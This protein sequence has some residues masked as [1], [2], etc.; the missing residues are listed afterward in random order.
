MQLLSDTIYGSF[1]DVAKRNPHKSALIHLGERFPYSQLKEMVL[2]FA[3]SLHGLGI[4]E[5]DRVILN[6]YNL[7]QAVIA[8]LALQRLKA[9]PILVA[10][11]YTSYDLKYMANDSG[12]ETIVCMDTNLR[13]VLEILPE[14][15]LKR[16]VVTNMI[17]LVPRWKRFIC[18]GF[19]R[20][21]K[22]KIPSGKDFFS[23]SKLLSGGH[24][25]VLPA[26]ESTGRDR[27]AI[28]LYTGG[29]T[30]FPKGVPLSEKLVLKRTLE[31]RRAS[32]GVSPLGEC[33]TILSAP[34]YHIIG[35]MDAYS[36][37][38]VGGE[39]LILLPRVVLDA[40]F[41]HIQRY[42]ATN[43]FAV[44]AMYRMIL[45]H[46][47][48]DYYDL[49]SLRYCGTGGDA[50]PAEVGHRWLKRFNIPLYQGYG[51]TELCGA[52]SLSFAEDGIPPE[53]SAGKIVQIGRAHV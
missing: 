33:I 2:R 26:F 13:Y 28:I 52:I 5:G 37:L 49:S 24:P 43:M 29:T 14:T 44:P 45:E 27:T 41:D 32:L 23:F 50:M 21:P 8:W 46:D 53:G 36:L 11:V 12:A 19:N 47:R 16:V 10:P 7:P 31:W 34:L 15:P 4:G 51:A 42:R 1:E 22:G 38:I 20:V 40:L 17:D 3:A 39:T 6:L 48:L 35:E 9:I 30:G 25:S 18:K